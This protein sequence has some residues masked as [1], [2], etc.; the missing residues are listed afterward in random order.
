MQHKQQ[1]RTN[2]FYTNSKGY[3][4][5][6]A[7]KLFIDTCSLRKLLGNNKIMFVGTNPEGGQNNAGHFLL[8]TLAQNVRQHWDDL[9]SG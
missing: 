3:H 4:I 5:L 6:L 1:L 8:Y 7:T 2:I 9:F